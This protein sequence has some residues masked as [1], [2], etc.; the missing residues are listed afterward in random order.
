M[1]YL[2]APQVRRYSQSRKSFLDPNDQPIDLDELEQSVDDF[3][4]SEEDVPPPP[5]SLVSMRDHRAFVEQVANYF[6]IPFEDD[7][8][9]QDLTQAILNIIIPLPGI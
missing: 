2:Y 8:P 4:D 9:V 5:P 1:S 3:S 7:T 6:G